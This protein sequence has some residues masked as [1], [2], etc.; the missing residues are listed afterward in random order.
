MFELLIIIGVIVEFIAFN[1]SIDHPHIWLVAIGAFLIFVGALP[2]I[3]KAIK[4]GKVDD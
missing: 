1:D 2:Y 3:I 4:T